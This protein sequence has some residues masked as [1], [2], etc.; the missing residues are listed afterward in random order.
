MLYAE[1]QIM[2]KEW[3]AKQVSLAVANKYECTKKHATHALRMARAEL[4]RF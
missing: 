4:L 1:R 2:S 3:Q